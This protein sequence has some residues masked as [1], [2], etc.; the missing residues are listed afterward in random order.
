ME[1]RTPSGTYGTLLTK[2]SNVVFFTL[3]SNKHKNIHKQTCTHK[4]VR[5]V[6]N[7]R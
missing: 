4:K 6:I 7:Q 3:T 1:Y 2:L 5:H